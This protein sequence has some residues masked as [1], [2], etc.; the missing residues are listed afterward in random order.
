MGIPTYKI[1][2]KTKIKKHLQTYTT[3]NSKLFTI[4]NLEQILSI[5]N[6]KHGEEWMGRLPYDTIPL[7][8]ISGHVHYGGFSIIVNKVQRLW[9]SI[10][11][12][13]RQL[14]NDTHC[15]YVSCNLYMTPAVNKQ[16]QKQKQ[17]SYSSSS[18]AFESHYDWMDVI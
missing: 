14:W 5:P 13:S 8:D 4:S 2:N 7:Q 11:I 15:N 17:N 1:T 10:S 12:L 3:T 6:L 18:A 9:K 16:Q